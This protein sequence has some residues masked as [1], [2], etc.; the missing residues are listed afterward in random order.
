MF[1]YIA[2]IK[3]ENIVRTLFREN[4]KAIILG[5]KVDS[6]FLKNKKNK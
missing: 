2:G 3:I 4:F 1:T 6:L 5:R